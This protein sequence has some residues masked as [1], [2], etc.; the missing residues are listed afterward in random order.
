MTSGAWGVENNILGVD[1][2]GLE[3]RTRRLSSMSPHCLFFFDVPL[4]IPGYP[5][6]IREAAHLVNIWEFGNRE[7]SSH[8]F[9]FQSG[10]TRFE[11]YKSLQ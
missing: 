3:S 10:L 11:L 6:E 7:F 9:I 1:S 2:D 8:C 5:N 4:N